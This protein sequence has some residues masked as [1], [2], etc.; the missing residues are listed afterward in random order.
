MREE[1]KKGKEDAQLFST[2]AALEMEQMTPPVGFICQSDRCT[3]HVEPSQRLSKPTMFLLAHYGYHMLACRHETPQIQ[4]CPPVKRF[5]CD[6]NKRPVSNGHRNA[7]IV[8]QNGYFTPES[9]G[10]VN[11]GFY[12][13]FFCHVALERNY[14]VCE[15]KSN[16]VVCQ[17][18]C[19]F[20]RCEIGVHGEYATALL[21]HS[22][23]GR[24]A[25]AEEAWFQ[26]RGLAG[27][28]DDG[29]LVGETRG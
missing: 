7:D 13:G 15:G 20:S 22:Q 3:I 9:H 2:A 29:G 28:V 12:F 1:G 11:C 24:A 26:R 27:A 14:G 18:R 17:V 21:G 5:L 25:V 8:M 16:L 10:L 4:L 23:D 19:F 6:S